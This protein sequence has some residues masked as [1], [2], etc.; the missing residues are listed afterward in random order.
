M[1]NRAFVLPAVVLFACAAAGWSQDTRLMS[2]EMED[3]FGA[4]HSDEE[5]REQVVVV[6]AGD[7]KGARHTV[8]W[9]RAMI[10][11]MDPSVNLSRVRYIQVADLK[12]VPSVGRKTVRKKF[13][14]D[15][16]QWSLLDWQGRWAKTYDFEKKAAN[17]LVFDTSGNLLVHAH[18]KEPD[19][20]QARALADAIKTAVEGADT[21]VPGGDD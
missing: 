18:G 13:P 8:A 19:E 1:T 5:Y 6:M 3:Q 12:S 21:I 9:G 11:A 17:I 15:E 2:F 14:Q 7:R 4:V 16:T 10:E 20:A